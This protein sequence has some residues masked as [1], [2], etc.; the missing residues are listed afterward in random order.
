MDFRPV[1]VVRQEG[2]FCA[3]VDRPRYDT[4]RSGSD[5]ILSL[6]FPLPRNETHY[7][8]GMAC[9]GV[10]SCSAA[11]RNAQAHQAAEPFLPCPIPI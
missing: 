3:T 2:V 6:P 4:T 10:S 7:S 8:S 5:R 1:V 11:E 9:T